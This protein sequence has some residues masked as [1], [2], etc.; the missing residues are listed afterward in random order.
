MVQDAHAPSAQRRGQLEAV[1][2]LDKYINDIACVLDKNIWRVRK[3]KGGE[4]YYK[5]IN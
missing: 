5:H 1:S 2:D 4:I 3:R